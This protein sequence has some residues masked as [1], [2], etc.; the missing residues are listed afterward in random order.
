MKAYRGSLI[1]VFVMVL[2]AVLVKWQQP[3]FLGPTVSEGDQIFSFE[4]HE[5]SR[6]SVERP[7]EDAIVLMEQDGTWIIE[8]SGHSAGRSM[9]NRIKHQIHDLTARAVVVETAD[10]PDLFGLG[11][12][13]TQVA[14]T[15][16]DGRQI[17]FKVGDPNPTSV[18]YYLQPVNSDV[19]FTVQKAAVDYYSLTLD[20]FRERRFATF[21]SKDV[22]SFTAKVNL[23]D[24]QYELVM[25]R[26]GARQW[27][28]T[29]PVRMAA[30]SD[31]ARRLL[32][33]ISALKA[34]RFEDLPDE[35]MDAL[36][37]TRPRVDMEIRFSSRPAMRIRVGNDAP[38]MSRFESLAYV[39]KDDDKTLYVARSGMLKTFAEDP[40]T[41]RNRRVVKME[42]EDVVA[43]DAVV[44][45]SDELELGGDAGVR[46]AAEQWVWK[47]GVPVSG[48]TPK[49]VAR[50]FAELEVEEFVAVSDGSKRRFGLDNPAAR[51]VLR[52]GDEAQRV[53]RIGSPGPAASDSEG[54]PRTRYYADVEGED[55]VYIVHSG[56][57]E[58]VRDL[59]RE[60]NRKE[61]RDSEKAA[62][63]E[64]IESVMEEEI[65]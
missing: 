41:L 11:S 30:D 2:L 8:S 49:R 46:Y 19:I 18:S 3:A 43:I 21:D 64:R 37:L 23:P 40:T 15:L 35:D 51:V 25:D 63:R 1:A 45:P 28:M 65:P 26:V 48:S 13:A 52:D 59:I 54:N 14:L 56:L 33:R 53:V 5:L 6:V 50:R 4:K 9:V 31:H 32:G 34:V 55:D 24:A 58:V 36:G 62:R 38:K 47:D 27:D 42:A 57:F 17:G 22:V 16:R 61:T 39:L 20:E 7:G 29:S 60:S 12:H 10:N 44:V